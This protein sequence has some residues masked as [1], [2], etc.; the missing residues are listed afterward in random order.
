VV[1]VTP[2]TTDAIG[3]KA[4]GAASATPAA[5]APIRDR[6]PDIDKSSRA[7]RSWCVSRPCRTSNSIQD[8]ER[9]LAKRIIA[10]P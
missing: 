7:G 9:F 8:Q 2:A 6:M 1:S 4:T 3:P 5:S 10:K